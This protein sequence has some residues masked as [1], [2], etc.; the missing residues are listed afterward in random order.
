MEWLNDGQHIEK[1]AIEVWQESKHKWE[2]VAEGQAIGHKKV[3]AFPAVT[4]A[5]VRLN[6][7]SSTGEAHI[8]EFQLYDWT[9]P[10]S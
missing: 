7:L 2:P 1:Y 5:H 3:D 6:I 9:N 8:R 4:A 10:G